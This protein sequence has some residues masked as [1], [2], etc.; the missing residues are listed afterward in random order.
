MTFG[1][2]LKL[3]FLTSLIVTASKS[4]KKKTK[5][6]SH[7][8]KGNEWHIIT[9]SGIKIPEIHRHVKYFQVNSDARELLT[10]YHE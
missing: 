9:E 7:G 10:S 3:F 8:P 6:L 4:H 1:F 5:K 2:G